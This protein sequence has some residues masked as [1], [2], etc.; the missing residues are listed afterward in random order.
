MEPR[1]YKQIL[2]RPEENKKYWLQGCDKEFQDMAPH[3]V[4][5]LIALSKVFNSRL[6]F[7]KKV[8]KLKHN[9]IYRSWLVAVG[10]TQIPRVDFTDLF[11]PVVPNIAMRILIILWFIFGWHTELV[12]VEGTFC[13]GFPKTPVYMYLPEGFNGPSNPCLKLI[14]SVYS[15]VQ[16]LRIWWKIFTKH[17]EGNWFQLSQADQCISIY[18]N[19]DDI[20]IL[21]Y[22]SMMSSFLEIKHPSNAPSTTLNKH[23]SSPPKT[24]YKIILGVNLPWCLKN[25]P[26]TSRN[27]IW[28]ISSLMNIPL[29]FQTSTIKNLG[30]LNSSPAWGPWTMRIF[31][32]WL[33]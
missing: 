1:T 17:L 28:L 4:W 23:L 32:L 2:K 6:L 29:S 16:S 11:T 14:K 9:G 10:F 3:K 20:Y 30:L 33:W 24:P 22:I 25:V 18:Q 12:D 26:L 27:S 5:K 19:Q 13:C 15:L 8:F 7:C 21:F 31:F